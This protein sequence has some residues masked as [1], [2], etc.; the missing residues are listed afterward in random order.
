MK[1]KL[2]RV[3][4]WWPCILFRA[5]VW[6][7]LIPHYNLNV[8]PSRLERNGS[9]FTDTKQWWKLS[10]FYHLLCNVDF[11]SEVR[12]IWHFSWGEVI[13][14]PFPFEKRKQ[15]NLRSKRK[16]SKILCFTSQAVTK[17]VNEWSPSWYTVS[18]RV[19]FEDHTI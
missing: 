18:S 11:R 14:S 12:Y 13:F 10:I 7:S 1:R 5:S 6:P 3:I 2:K 17:A 19:L 9:T 8:R 4:F 16:K 15:K